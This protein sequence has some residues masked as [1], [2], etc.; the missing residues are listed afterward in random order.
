MVKACTLFL[1]LIFKG[2]AFNF[3][4]LSL[5]CPVDLLYTALSC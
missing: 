3:S 1:F 2:K 4:M 5:M